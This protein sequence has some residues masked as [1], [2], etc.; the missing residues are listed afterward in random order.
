MCSPR[1]RTY[2]DL[3]WQS[4]VPHRQ[5][6]EI[7]P[8]LHYCYALLMVSKVKAKK[9]GT[10]PRERRGR[11]TQSRISAKNQVTL[12]VDLLR[13]SGLKPGDGVEFVLS[14]KG[15]LEVRAI[16]NSWDD[17]CGLGDGVYD[18]FDLRKERDSWR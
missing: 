2:L 8:V 16:S 17:F 5:K 6:D 4:R 12:P 10:S 13:A 9:A 11:T 14:P 15:V 1:D 7:A 18:S 3:A